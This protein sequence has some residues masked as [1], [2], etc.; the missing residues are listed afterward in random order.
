MRNILDNEGNYRFLPKRIR[1]FHDQKELFKA[2]YA[3]TD[4]NNIKFDS[5]YKIGWTQMMV[6]IMDVFLYNMAL[7]G[8]T[9]QRDDR[10]KEIGLYEFREENPDSSITPQTY[11]NGLEQELA[12]M[13]LA[14]EKCDHIE[15]MSLQETNIKV[16]CMNVIIDMIREN[17]EQDG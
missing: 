9:L 14:R 17:K 5:F 3:D 7:R 16:Q 1:D 13:K 6:N 8:F 15:A 12:Y 2:I 4:Y 11:N 10:F